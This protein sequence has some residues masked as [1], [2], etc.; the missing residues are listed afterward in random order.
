MNY[1]LRTEKFSGPLEKLLELIEEKR[2][3]ITEL[4]LAAVTADFLK[5][6]QGIEAAHPRILAD[7]V[8]VA[9]RLLLIKSKALLPNLELTSEEEKSIKDFEAQ[10]RFYQSFKPALGHLKTLW[11]RKK[12]SAG[13]QFMAGRPIIFYP[14]ANVTMKNLER[15]VA[16]IFDVLNRLATE[17]G[18]IKSSLISLEE[19]I[20]EIINL[21]K[22]SKS[23]NALKF[24]ELKKEKSKAEI[25]VM[26]LALLHLLHEQLVRVEQKGKFSDMRIFPASGASS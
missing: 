12:F 2:L 13:R 10:L 8:V 16:A 11:D 19:K 26:F 21:F 15:A 5:Y 22:K 4:S 14:S 6:L 3:E 18:T 20:Q 7:F 24:K 9:S 17:T 23:L 25:I 1:E